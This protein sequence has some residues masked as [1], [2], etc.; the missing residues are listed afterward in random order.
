MASHIDRVCTHGTT[1]DN[2]ISTNT[3]MTTLNAAFSCQE[4]PS[5]VCAHCGDVQLL[6]KY[7]CGGCRDTS[8][9]SAKCQTEDWK[10]HKPVCAQK[11]PAN[12]MHQFYDVLINN[13]IM[14]MALLA[15]CL[16]SGIITDRNRLNGVGIEITF[17]RPL[18][19]IRFIE[20]MY[21]RCYMNMD[22][23][24]VCDNTTTPELHHGEKQEVPWFPK[25][26]TLLEE[27]LVICKSLHVRH[28]THECVLEEYKVEVQGDE[29]HAVYVI[30]YL[31]SVDC[32]AL[33][34]MDIGNKTEDI[35]LETLLDVIVGMI[36]KDA[37]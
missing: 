26:T 23:D 7:V 31:E 20:D 2:A 5:A 13:R 25:N 22:E 37:P 6:A 34:R 16:A 35:E 19:C 27:V 10:K 29:T 3:T 36:K 30:V 15:R 12:A 32:S 14:H 33:Y 1:V 9:C 21:T 24:N 11:Q 28:M 8:Y 18:D 17:K 4:K